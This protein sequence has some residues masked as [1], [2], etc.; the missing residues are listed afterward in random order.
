MTPL[1]CDK[2]KDEEDCIALIGTP[3]SF[4][5]DPLTAV[6]SDMIKYMLFY[7]L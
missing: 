4:N 1:V 6:G 2:S 3:I 5:L 7:F